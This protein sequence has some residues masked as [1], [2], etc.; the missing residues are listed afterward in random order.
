MGVD[1]TGPRTVTDTFMN[2]GKEYTWS[3]GQGVFQAYNAKQVV[4]PNKCARQKTDMSE[5]FQAAPASVKNSDTLDRFISR[6]VLIF[7]QAYRLK[8]GMEVEKTES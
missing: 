6:Q 4:F 7:G 3:Y 2:E 8:T 1:C 5:A